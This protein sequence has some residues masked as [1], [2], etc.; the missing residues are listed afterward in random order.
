MPVTVTPGGA[1]RIEPD[2]DVTRTP[3]SPQDVRR[4]NAK[5]IRR[6]LIPFPK[7]L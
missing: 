2:E 1:D 6:E 5:E 7:K 4:E 3:P